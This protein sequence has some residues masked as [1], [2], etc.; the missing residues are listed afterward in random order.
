MTEL[1][2]NQIETITMEP[3]K[4]ASYID[5]TLLKADAKP[6]DIEKLCAEARQHR[7]FS[8]CVNSANVSQAAK[9][10]EGSGVNVCAVVGFPLGA[11]AS[12][13][14]AYEARAAIESGAREIDMVMNIGAMKS[15][16][17]KLV[18]NDML[19]VRT[20]CGTVALLKVILETCLLTTEEI[21]QACQIAKSLSLDFVKTSTGFSTGGAT[22][23]HIA[24]MRQTVGAQMGVKA[25]GGVRTFADALAMINA[26]A[27]RLGTSGGISIINGQTS[28]GY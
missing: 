20:A 6:A 25:S 22:V 15:G 23:E 11:M 3:G 12:T 26:G 19:A 21:V 14:K 4:L 18:E 7:F 24:L 27:T 8:V 5:H 10:L 9:L 16:D 1:A 13:A 17:F 2:K 28:S